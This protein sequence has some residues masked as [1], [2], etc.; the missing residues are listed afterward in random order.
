MGKSLG[1]KYTPAQVV[2]LTGFS[3]V[4]IKLFPGARNILT[5]ILPNRG[6]ILTLYLKL[7]IAIN[8]KQL[9]TK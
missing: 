9:Y 5:F 2:S 4:G 6:A 3:T 7:I 1:G 8:F